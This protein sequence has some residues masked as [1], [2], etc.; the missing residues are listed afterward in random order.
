MHNLARG[1]GKVPYSAEK[2]RPQ[3]RPVLAETAVFEK[4]RKQSVPGKFVQNK[5]RVCRKNNV[6]ISI[7]ITR[8]Y[9]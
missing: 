4:N 9:A 7:A 8:R 3:Y 6:R 2:L 5:I 1:G